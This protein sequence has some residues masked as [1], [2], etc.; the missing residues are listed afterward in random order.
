MATEKN[1]SGFNK[2]KRQNSDCLSNNSE[3]F[4]RIL[5]FDLKD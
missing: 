4:C 1:N 3:F 2:I 5:T